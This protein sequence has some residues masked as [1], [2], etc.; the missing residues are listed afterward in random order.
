MAIACTICVRRGRRL[1]RRRED[2]AN[3]ALRFSPYLAASRWKVSLREP[4][5]RQRNMNK[6]CCSV[7]T[8]LA[9]W[10]LGNCC[11]QLAVHCPTYR[12]TFSA[13]G[14]SERKLRG[15]D[16]HA[17]PESISAHALNE[18]ASFTATR[19]TPPALISHTITI[20]DYRLDVFSG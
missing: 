16:L 8:L 7:R 5:W 10:F 11:S 20:L 17:F 18:K 9:L 1:V 19:Y 3:I 15:S 6:Q 14:G 13:E 4:Q 12:A 2:A